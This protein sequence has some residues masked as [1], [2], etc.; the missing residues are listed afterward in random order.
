MKGVGLEAEAEAE[1]EVVLV[2]GGI[3]VVTTIGMVSMVLKKGG[4]DEDRL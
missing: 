4:K 1:A 2:G 3:N